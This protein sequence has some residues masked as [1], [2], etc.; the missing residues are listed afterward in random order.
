MNFTS[1]KKKASVRWETSAVSGV[2]VTIVHPN[3]HRKPLHPLSH[4]LHDVDV[5]REK[6]ASEAEVRLA[7]F[8]DNHAVTFCKVLVRDHL[9]SIDILPNVNFVKLNRD[10]KLEISVFPHYKV[11]EQ[12]NKEPDKSFQNGKSEDKGAVAFM[13]IVRKA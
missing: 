3:R 10:V 2:R 4:Q 9:V 11:D 6:E 7:E 5:C 1:V 12:S 13:N 8:F